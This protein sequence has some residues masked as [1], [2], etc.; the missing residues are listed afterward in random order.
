MDT[1]KRPGKS[2]KWLAIVLILALLIAIV[3][4]V[5]Q[6]GRSAASTEQAASEELAK[7]GEEP[8]AASSAAALQEASAGTGTEAVPT[9]SPSAQL[10]S[11]ELTEFAAWLASEEDGTREISGDLV[12]PSLSYV[13]GNKTLTGSGSIRMEAAG[14]YV[15]VL[16]ENASLTL[17]GPTIDGTGSAINGIYVP[18]SGS[19]TMKSGSI[20]N[21]TGHGIRSFGKTEISGGTVRNLGSS[22]LIAESGSDTSLLGGEF[23]D[24][25]A[26]GIVTAQ[27]SSLKIGNAVTLSGAKSNLV[28]NCGSLEAEGGN[29]SDAGDYYFHNEGNLVLTNTDFSGAVLLG[30]L[31]NIA[32]GT[33]TVR[34]GSMTD[35]KADFIFNKGAMTIDGTEFNNCLSTA[36]ENRGSDS[37][38]TIRSCSF[39]QIGKAVLLNKNTTVTAEDLTIGTCGSYVVHN[40]ASE[41]TGKNITAQYA[42]EIAF[43]ND[44]GH[45]G[46]TNG[47][48]NLTVDGFSIGGT[49][50]Y[51]IR[52]NGG[53]TTLRN[54]SMGK[55]GNYSLYVRHGE[56]ITDTVDF[57]GITDGSRAVIQIGLSTAPDGKVTMTETNITGGARGIT[58]NGELIFNSGSIYGNRSAGN[59]NIGAGINNNGTLVMNGGSIHDNHAI[60]SGGGI[61]NQGVCTLGPVNIYCNSTDTSGGG[62]ATKTALNI[63][64]A[65]ITVN[66]ADNYGGGVYVNEQGSVAMWM[67]C[68]SDNEAGTGGGGMAVSGAANLTGGYVTCNT[69]NGMGGGVYVGRTGSLILSDDIEVTY[70]SSDNEKSGG[71]VYN[72]GTTKMKG[73]T[74]AYNTAYT[75]GGG[76]SNSTSSDGK[77]S[78]NLVITGGDIYSNEAATKGGGGI[79][80]TGKA[81]ISNVNVYG[82]KVASGAYGSAI[83]NAG[84]LRLSGGTYDKGSSGL[85]AAPYDV[86]AYKGILDIS[87]DPEFLSI[88]KGADGH[89]NLEDNLLT[90]YNYKLYLTNYNLGTE[91]L[92]GS[93]EL[94]LA[95]RDRF[96]LPQEVRDAGKSIDEEGLISDGTDVS[97]VNAILYKDGE[98]LEEGNF[99]VLL[100]QVQEEGGYTI[101]LTQDFETGGFTIGN[102]TILGGGNTLTINSGSIQVA[103]DTTAAIENIN[104]EAPSG[105]NY[106]F[107]R[108]SGTLSITDTSISGAENA[109]SS[110]SGGAINNAG[111][112]TLTNVTI[113]DCKAVGSG[114]AVFNGSAGTLTVSGG[115]ISSSS[116]DKGG[117]LYNSGTAVLTDGVS[118]SGNRSAG[119]G[120][121]IYQNNGTLT[122]EDADISGN[123]YSESVSGRDIHYYNGKL[124][125]GSNANVDSIYLTSGKTLQLTETLDS[126]ASIGIELNAS[127]FAAGTT[128]LTGDTAA[129][130]D[131]VTNDRVTLINNAGKSEEEITI[132]LDTD[133][134]LVKVIPMTYQAWVFSGSDTSGTPDFK[135]T[136]EDALA[137]VQDG[138]T[139]VLQQAA[140]Y[141]SELKIG[142][143]TID[144]TENNYLTLGN[145]L[146]VGSSV[147]ATV[148]NVKFNKAFVTNEGTLTL[149]DCSISGVSRSVNGAAI[150]NKSGAHLI[151]NGGSIT[152]CVCTGS[153]GGGAISSTGS[154]TTAVLTDV[155][156]SGNSTT[157]SKGVGG[158]IRN[159][160]G[161][162][163]TLIDCTVTGNSSKNPGADI[164][165]NGTLTLSGSTEIGEV[166]LNS[167]KTI[168]LGDAIDAGV[169]VTMQTF[170]VGET[171]LS[172][173]EVS[174]ET[175]SAA[176]EQITLLDNAGKAEEDITVKLGSSGVLVS[177]APE[178]VYEAYAYSGTDDSTEPV[179][180]GSFAEAVQKVPDGGC[181]YVKEECTYTGSSLPSC[182]IYGDTKLT[183]GGEITIGSGTSVLI[184]KTNFTKAL[185]NSGGSVSLIN[186]NF[187]DIS[188]STNGGAINNKDGGSLY[189]LFGSISNCKGTG[190]YGAGAINNNGSGTTAT[191]CNVEITDCQATKA[192]GGGIRNNNSAELTLDECTV[193]GNSAKTDG[194]DVW[195]NGGTLT[196][197]DCDIGEIFL[198]NGKSI[199]LGTE[200]TGDIKIT[201]ANCSI[202]QV[203]ATGDEDILKDSCSHLILNTSEKYAVG[204][205]GKVCDAAALSAAE[206]TVDAPAASADGVQLTNPAVIS[207]DPAPAPE[208]ASLESTSASAKSAAAFEPS[209]DS[210][211]SDSPAL[212]EAASAV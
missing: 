137:Q 206:N 209:G 91:A 199:V 145:S 100:L 204:A 46:D 74:I 203:V 99:I 36:I 115:S 97:T 120:G 32:G 85:E 108:N 53:L 31:E 15:L 212:D 161:A 142:S 141:D 101:E 66:S 144:G 139:I 148:K 194:Q 84:S 125:A 140:A 179:F 54:G 56:V 95:N 154:A 176:C 76:I 50:H 177:A 92:T 105:N 210:E 75:Y 26:Q 16:D 138:G 111:S 159:Q 94:I 149:I 191:L 64:G 158:G 131:A 150:N 112:M 57:N 2:K 128:V 78:G 135:G 38:L 208:S 167:G 198:A 55:T 110:H 192:M 147:A 47:C 61:Y 124:L 51:G 14:E 18:A 123:S 72:L 156:I 166:Y 155:V 126:S 35:S 163:L 116:A 43:Y 160:S 190:S 9:A 65:T 185:T 44:Y 143:Y 169:G 172:A 136:F 178:A 174:A 29:Y 134:K 25:G 3:L 19:L 48:G 188:R 58:N 118:I 23:T 133:G 127:S 88:Y 184:A 211:N 162:S 104:L 33:V 67:G 107:I 77:K 113:S 24:S 28:Y 183:I 80:N 79:Y 197:K 59:T 69:S 1:N 82:N 6:C 34:G 182:S 146:T 11:E 20:E 170:A 40:R 151:M 173:G 109:D 37:S 152:D 93:T 49:G 200:Q 30:Y 45:D 73:G 62:V 129:V 7:A 102:N 21:L 193:T 189:M 157:N 13:K 8:T 196:I 168:T 83:Y 90:S 39:D 96:E 89:I 201:M 10:Q 195:Q 164:W 153:V 52:T 68:I 180:K 205:D 114:G 130:S 175:L 87:N 41:F 103:A 187:S 60:S 207:N 165:Q 119:N 186:C 22:W 106:A 5:T 42:A 121:G 132:T 122:I 12:L 98:K 27:D 117:G 181:I 17:D 4:G 86:Y 81:Q 63:A 171:V 71:G 202:G 70:N